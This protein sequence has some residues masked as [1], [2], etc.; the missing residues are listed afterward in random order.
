[1]DMYLSNKLDH[2]S[3]S[4]SLFFCMSYIVY[5]LTLYCT[6]P[7]FSLLFIPHFFNLN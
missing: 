2:S 3:S 4:L 5:F 6:V 1:M 7:P